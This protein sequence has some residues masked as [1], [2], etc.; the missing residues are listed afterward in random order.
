MVYNK[1]KMQDGEKVFETLVTAEEMLRAE[2]TTESYL[3]LMFQNAKI[4]S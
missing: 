2:E 1:W 3:A 4:P